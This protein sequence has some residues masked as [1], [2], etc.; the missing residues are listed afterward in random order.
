MD[1]FGDNPLPLL[2][3]SDDYTAQICVSAQEKSGFDKLLHT[4]ADTLAKRLAHARL[5]IPYER[6]DIMSLLFQSARVLEQDHTE[7]G[8]IVDV[9]MPASL[10]E[11]YKDYEYVETE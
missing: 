2:N 9:E 3:D 7:D 6:G 10:Y 4:I 1:K 5:L 11:R 8:M